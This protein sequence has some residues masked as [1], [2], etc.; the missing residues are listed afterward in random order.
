MQ[1]HSILWQTW[2]IG[3][4]DYGSAD[5]RKIRCF[6]MDSPPDLAERL[7]IFYSPLF[8]YYYIF[9]IKNVKKICSEPG[10]WRHKVLGV[11]V[12]GVIARLNCLLLLW[13]TAGHFTLFGVSAGRAELSIMGSGWG[14]IGIHWRKRMSVTCLWVKHLYAIVLEPLTSLEGIQGHCGLAEGNYI[15][16]FLYPK[17]TLKV[18]NIISFTSYL[19]ESTDFVFC[20]KTY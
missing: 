1:R 12:A 7:N 9:K 20:I 5:R 6:L 13:T 17:S 15:P 4:G 3:P 10:R 18:R 14:L 2:L 16:D 8:Y 19:C 11:C